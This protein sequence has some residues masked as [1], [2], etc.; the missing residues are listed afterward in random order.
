MQEH[1][2]PVIA[3]R[4]SPTNLGLALLA[5]FTAWDFGY[6]ATGELL[7]RSRA[8]LRHGPPGAP[9]RPLL[10]LVRHQNAGAA[11]ADVRVGGRQR[12]PGRPLAD[13]GR[14]PGSSW[15]TQPVASRIRW[16]ASA[17]TCAWSR[18]TRGDGAAR[19]AVA[20]LWDC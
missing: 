1:P 16:T 18:N 6:A 5:N 10:Q 14:R 20:G 7:Q 4:T 2:A 9:P 3:H 12:Q 15:P 11:A 8:T 13:P 19:A 17:I